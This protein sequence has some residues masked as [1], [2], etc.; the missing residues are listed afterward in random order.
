MVVSLGLGGFALSY[1]SILAPYQR[2]IQFATI[3]LL[4]WA[5]Y[6]MDRQPMKRS[7][8]IFIWVATVNVFLFMLSPFIT[9]L[10]SF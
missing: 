1:V 8:K 9:R 3:G 2:Y 10:L 6:R 7:T 4:M 5:H